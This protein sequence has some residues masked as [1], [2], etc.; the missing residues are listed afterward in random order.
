MIALTTTKVVNA[1]PSGARRTSL[2]GVAEIVTERERASSLALSPDAT[3]AVLDLKL[4]NAGGTNHR[5]ISANQVLALCQH[6]ILPPAITD[7]RNICAAVFSRET[8][9]ACS[10]LTSKQKPDAPMRAGARKHQRA[11]LLQDDEK[12]PGR[13]RS[14]SREREAQLRGRIYGST[15]PWTLIAS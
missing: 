15:G 11:A 8:I 4:W 14:T 7:A 12:S 10:S 13:A 1:R 6:Q 9:R 2:A 5:R 3:L